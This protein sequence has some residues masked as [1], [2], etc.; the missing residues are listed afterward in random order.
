MTFGEEAY[1]TATLKNLNLVHIVMQYYLGFV[2]S[3]P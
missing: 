1:N 2:K 3:E